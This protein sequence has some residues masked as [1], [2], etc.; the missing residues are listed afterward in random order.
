MHINSLI[1]LFGQKTAAQEAAYEEID[2]LPEVLEPQADGSPEDIVLSTLKRE[3]S[4]RSSQRHSR[5]N[6]R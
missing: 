3:N 2:T 5:Q 6:G 4:L 1:F